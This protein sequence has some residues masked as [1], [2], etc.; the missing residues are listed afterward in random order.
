[1]RQLVRYP[2]VVLSVVCVLAAGAGALIAAERSSRAMADAATAFVNSLTPEQRQQAVFP[3]ESD[4]RLRWHFIPTEGFPRKG[5]TVKEMT[6]PQRALAHALLKAGL[7]Q[8]GYTTATAI[9]ELETLLGA[10]ERREREGGRQAEGFGRDPVRYFFSVF[11]TP[12]AKTAWGWRVEGHHVSLHFTMANGNVIA[13]SPSMFGSNPAE[14]LEGPTKGTRI[15]AAR[16]DTARELLMSLD[17]TQRTQAVING[18][19][20]ND[21]VTSN[22]LS[23]T[24][25]SPVG[26]EAATLTARQRDLLMKVVDT[27]VGAMADDVAADRMAQLKKAGLEKIA[28]AWAGEAERGKKHYYRIQG[29]TF[30]IEYDN[31]QNNGNHIHSVWRDFTNDFGRDLLREHI[32]SVAH[33]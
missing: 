5:L 6:E 23:I 20:P 1:M 28:F 4:E 27:Y 26:V 29:P 17:A 25:L 32:A 14:V 33:Q 24:P 10:L 31:S 11:G 16:E 15:L 13:T 7:S 30:L 2:R 9:M 3:F 8:R 22:R 19:A 21:I 12:S 18:V